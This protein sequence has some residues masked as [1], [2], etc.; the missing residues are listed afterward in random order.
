[1]IFVVCVNDIISVSSAVPDSTLARAGSFP[2]DFS[3]I[4]LPHGDVLDVMHKL[5]MPLNVHFILAAQRKPIQS[6]VL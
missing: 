3:S 2:R 5:N 4:R 1:M 6:L